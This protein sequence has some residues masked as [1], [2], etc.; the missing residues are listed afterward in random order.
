M[1]QSTAQVGREA[2]LDPMRSSHYP[3]HCREAQAGS[4]WPNILCSGHLYSMCSSQILLSNLGHSRSWPCPFTGSPLSPGDGVSLCSQQSQV[5]PL[6]EMALPCSP[7]P[8]LPSPLT[9]EKLEAN[10]GREEWAVE[11]N[12]AA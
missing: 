8:G 9:T 3:V 10:L 11:E 5:A 4:L 6:Q 7:R 1:D 2:G 12:V